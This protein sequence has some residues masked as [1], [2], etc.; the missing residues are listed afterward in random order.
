MTAKEYLNRLR[1]IELRLKANASEI[2]HL[3]EIATHI[4]SAVNSD[5]IHVSGGTSDKLASCV[6]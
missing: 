5:G 1:S 4:T 3:M 2:E 6:S